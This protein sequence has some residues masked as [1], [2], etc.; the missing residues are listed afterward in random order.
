MPS[1]LAY[2]ANVGFGEGR[3]GLA[4][5]STSASVRPKVFSV[6]EIIT[7]PDDFCCNLGIISFVHINSISRGGPGMVI[8]IRLSRSTHQPGAVPLGLG[9]ISAD[10]ITLACF[11]LVGGI[12]LLKYL[13]NS[14]NFWTRA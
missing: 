4:L 13:N 2:V 9:I 8:I 5:S 11:M 10:G 3:N 7:A 6:L 12:S 14:S 1:I